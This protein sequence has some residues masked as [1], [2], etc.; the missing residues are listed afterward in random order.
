VDLRAG[1]ISDGA[2]RDSYLTQREE[3]RRLAELERA[4]AG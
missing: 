4:W 1:F 2:L 3:N